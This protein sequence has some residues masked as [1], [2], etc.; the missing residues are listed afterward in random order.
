M[1]VTENVY[2]Q[3]SVES[4]SS[5]VES[6]K[7]AIQQRNGK[8]QAELSRQQAADD[9]CSLFASKADPFVK[10][11]ILYKSQIT[12]S[13]ESLEGQ[14]AF[15]KERIASESKDGSSLSDINGLQSQLDTAAIQHNRHS[16]HTAKDLD[17]QWKQYLSFLTQKKIQLEEEIEHKR[18]RGVTPQQYAEIKQQFKQF[19]KNGNGFLDRNE[20]KACL[21]SLGD[22]R[23]RSEVD[24]IMQKYVA[25]ESK[26]GIAYDG[27]QEFMIS[28]LGDSDTLD[29]IIQ[30]FKLINKGGDVGND[31]L[32]GL[33]L[34]D[35][36]IQYLHGQ[37]SDP[38]RFTDWT[39]DVFSR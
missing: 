13:K 15:V 6:V 22:E 3:Q 16:L 38:I 4:L 34:S 39:K 1:G 27:F 11:L 19:D 28:Q 31:E 12:E 21:Y 14:L 18:L 37:S 5:D 35:E 7:T 36:D 10:Q 30:G 24:K 26:N 9:L 33:L 29:E 25:P 20:F 17:L 32:M 2:T 23:P 8:Y